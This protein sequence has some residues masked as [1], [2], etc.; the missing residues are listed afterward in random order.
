MALKLASCHTWAGSRVHSCFLSTDADFSTTTTHT[1]RETNALR[2]SEKSQASH[3]GSNLLH[4]LNGPQSQN[5]EAKEVL[6]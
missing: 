3:L 6:R 5:V 1:S 4:F 2:N